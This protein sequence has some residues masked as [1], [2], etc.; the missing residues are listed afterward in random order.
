VKLLTYHVVA[1][2][3]PSSKLLHG[4]GIKSVEGDYLNAT[5]EKGSIMINQAKVIAADNN[6]SNGVVHIVNGVLTFP[7][8]A[9]P[10][11]VDVAVATPYLSTLVTALKAADL[12]DT[13]SGPGPFTV[14][15]P[16]NKAFAALPA[17]LLNKL[18]LPANKAYLVKVLTYH[19]AAGDVHAKDIEREHGLILPTVE[20]RDLICQ[21]SQSGG[22]NINKY[23]GHVAQANVTSAD[24]NAGNGVVHIIDGVLTCP[25]CLPP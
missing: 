17:G 18:L 22:I 13:L 24:N 25:A 6:A 11:I 12:V 5:V 2:D 8:F 4:E 19:V 16:T 21:V 3:I 10:T 9:L 23:R 1:A 20:G 14:F 7:G 15:A